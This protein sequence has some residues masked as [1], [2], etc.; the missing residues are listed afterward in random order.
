[1]AKPKTPPGGTPPGQQPPPS[2]GV[3]LG[4]IAA[5]GIVTELRR[6]G[7]E[8]D[9]LQPGGG[10]PPIDLT[11]LIDALNGNTAALIEQATA[12]RD[13]VVATNKNAA[14]I[15]NHAEAV[16]KNTEAIDGHSAALEDHMAA[17]N[18]NTDAIA[19]LTEAMIPKP[20]MK[21]TRMTMSA[22]KTTTEVT[23]M[24]IQ[25]YPNEKG[26]VTYKFNGTIDADP[27]CFAQGFACAS[28]IES[29]EYDATA[30]ETT[31]V[32]EFYCTQPENIVDGDQ[33]APPEHGGP[34]PGSSWKIG[35]PCTATVDN[36][37]TATIEKLHQPY[38][39]T[40]EWI[41][42]GVTKA[43]SIG[44]TAEKVQ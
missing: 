25:L 42:L 23:T 36:P 11:G 13:L 39:D 7:D 32:M 24:P 6:I 34:N 15:E 9:Q 2:S 3:D 8:I 38:P 31:V 27:I 12:T 22:G 16:T 5:P 28:T 14:E 37:A 10:G 21:A 30:K 19:A 29:N 20:P 40:F 33:S 43:T 1:M 18:A 17:L 26:R 44:M 35:V 4:L 41:P